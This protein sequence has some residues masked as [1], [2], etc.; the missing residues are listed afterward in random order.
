MTG[1]Y[2]GE[3][4][5][6]SG[7][8]KRLGR[9]MM[10]CAVVGAMSLFVAACGSGTNSANAS[11][12]SSS[13]SATAKTSGSTA[14]SSS[15]TTTGPMPK[16]T[17]AYTAPVSDQML[18]LVAKADGLFKKYGVTVT[19][20]YLP[21]TEANDSLVSGQIQMCVY[22][23][24]GPEVL[25]ASGQPIKWIATWEHHTGLM[26]MGRNGVKT[27]ADLATKPV[28]ITVAGTT[29][30]V[31]SE[32]ILNKAGVL[33][34]AHLQPLGNV[35]ALVSA[36]QAGSVDAIIID[37]PAQNTLLKQVS[38]SVI[39]SNLK[40]G[41]TWIGGGIATNETW[42][43]AHK[44]TAVK[45]MK[46]LIAAQK[47]Y[48]T[49]KSKTTDVKVIE[50]SAKAQATDA[51]PAYQVTLGLMNQVSSMVPSLSVEKA[52]I[53]VI[54]PVTPKVKTLN[55]ATVID[56]SYMTTAAK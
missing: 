19:I 21:A 26:L 12:T 36:F 53:K 55:A 31:L 4:T 51:E 23:A 17:M 56:T 45:V 48:K 14:T 47:Y 41:F 43:S 39:L 42:A 44:S 10:A 27:V 13:T 8:R 49:P 24:P 40:T 38:G 15:T 37:P 25:N 46:A 33:S 1:R 11:K 9:G 2:G 28:G 5:P 54:A 34:K 22:S 50:T 20:K 35:G 29:T 7:R 32:I 18:P 52:M 16:V 6:E 3:G 30:A